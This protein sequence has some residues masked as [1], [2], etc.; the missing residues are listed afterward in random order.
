MELIFELGKT[1]KLVGSGLDGAKCNTMREERK[2]ERVQFG[3]RQK[4][5]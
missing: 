4:V 2:H 3:I 5:S 1:I